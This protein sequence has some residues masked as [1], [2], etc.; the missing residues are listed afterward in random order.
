MLGVAAISPLLAFD[1]DHEVLFRKEYQSLAA[2]RKRLKAL[3]EYQEIENTVQNGE[4]GYTSFQNLDQWFQLLE[5]EKIKQPQS[6]QRSLKELM[7]FE[8][9]LEG[10][11][12]H[13]QRLMEELPGGTLSERTQS[14]PLK[15]IIEAIRKFVQAGKMEEARDLLNQTLKVFDQ[16]NQQVKKQ[17]DSYY[18]Q[19]FAEW[20]SSLK[21]LQQ[22][23]EQAKSMELELDQ[24]LNQDKPETALIPNST[25]SSI[26]QWNELQSRQQ[27]VTE[28][29]KKFQQQLEDLSI[30]ALIPLDSL[31]MLGHEWQTLSL[32]TENHFQTK[33][34]PSAIQGVESTLNT[35]EQ[36]NQ[37]LVSLGQQAQQMSQSSVPQTSYTGKRRYLSEKA[38]RPMRFDYDFKV[39]PEFRQQIQES[40]QHPNKPSPPQKKYIHEVIR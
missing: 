26:P 40:N 31:Q 35:L 32:Q 25:L 34:L 9:H 19:Q 37:T 14:L 20:E 5:K 23:I 29:S 30:P 4:D 10:L 16:Q 15:G 11:L 3:L 1:N 33:N 39:N 7:E 21:Q 12:E 18:K 28:I 13:Q 2:V 22:S 27:A 24:K 6:V 38:A 36:L 17:I 8:K